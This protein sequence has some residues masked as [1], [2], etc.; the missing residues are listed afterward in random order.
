M[1]KMNLSAI[2]DPRIRAQVLSD[3]RIGYFED[4]RNGASRWTI[5][6]FWPGS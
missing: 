1:A 3:S 2:L 6:D 4:T 5:G